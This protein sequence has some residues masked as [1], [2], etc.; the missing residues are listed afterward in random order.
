MRSSRSTHGKDIHV[1]C[2]ISDLIAFL[3]RM[4]ASL[5]E[6]STLIKEVNVSARRKGAKLAFSTVYRDKYSMPAAAIQLHL[7]LL[8]GSRGMPSFRNLGDII[9]GEE[10]CI[11]VF[12]WQ[13]KH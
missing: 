8:C 4:D 2:S 7:T 6:I 3:E 10:V 11:R 1:V 13:V 5:K 12:S 9:N